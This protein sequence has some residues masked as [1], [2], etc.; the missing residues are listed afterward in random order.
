MR[1]APPV[2]GST[3]SQSPWANKQVKAEKHFRLPQ[4]IVAGNQSSGKSSV[5]EAIAGVSDGKLGRVPC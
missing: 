2:S 1:F 3:W 4:I 5:L